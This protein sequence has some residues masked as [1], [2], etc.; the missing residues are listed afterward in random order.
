VEKFEEEWLWDGDDVQ[1]SFDSQDS[2][3]EEHYAND[4]PDEDDY[5][6]ENSADY[7]PDLAGSDSCEY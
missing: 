4:Y 1:S 6:S 3:N 5:I 2:N 7:D